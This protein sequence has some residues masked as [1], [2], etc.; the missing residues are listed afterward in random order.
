LISRYNDIRNILPLQQQ[1]SY[2]LALINEVLNN[3]STFWISLDVNINVD[4][5]IPQI[6]IYNAI[7]KFHNLHRS[8]EEQNILK[9]EI[10]RLV[11]FWAKQNEKIEN[12]IAELEKKVKIYLLNH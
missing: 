11:D 4:I 6:V 9:T 2:P 12:V 10:T 3:Q 5:Q 8:K 1:A 7:Q